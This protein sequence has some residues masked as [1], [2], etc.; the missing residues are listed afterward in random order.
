MKKFLSGVAMMLAAGAGE[1]FAAEATGTGN[2]SAKIVEPVTISENGTGLNFG[3]MLNS[4]Q[5]VT[6]DTTGNRTSTVSSALVNG[7]T[8]QAGKFNVTGPANQELTIGTNSS[9][10]VSSGSN[11]MTVSN[12]VTS[13]SGTLTLSDSGAG[14]I[15]VGADLTVPS[16]QA[17]GEYTGT[18]TITLSY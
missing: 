3:I 17:A 13:P 4:E 6:V 7:I 9:A 1:S 2:I 16:K 11:N 15:A 18:Y 12:F 10:I 5:T 8:P 14:D